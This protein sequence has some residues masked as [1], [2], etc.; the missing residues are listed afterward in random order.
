MRKD[1]IKKIQTT[2]ENSVSVDCHTCCFSDYMK[3]YSQMTSQQDVG[4]SLLLSE[5]KIITK[6][7]VLMK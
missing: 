3:L 1:V 5:N 6:A 7:V 4:S 2:G